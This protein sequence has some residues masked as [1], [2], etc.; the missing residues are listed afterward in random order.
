MWYNTFYISKLVSKKTFSFP[1][2]TKIV[3]AKIE[4]LQFII[5]LS[6]RDISVQIDITAEYH[7][8]GYGGAL[9][10]EFNCIV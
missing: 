5:L 3:P 10:M 4:I 2:I 1:V 7:Q 9:M 6:F 8:N